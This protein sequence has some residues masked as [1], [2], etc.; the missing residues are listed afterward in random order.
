MALG[1]NLGDTPAGAD[2][3][4]AVF[5]LSSGTARPVPYAALRRQAGA[6][7][8]RLR[9]RGLPRGA[10][11][12]LLGANS[13]AFLAA[14]FGILRAGLV[15]VPVNWRL[16]A[17]TVAFILADAGAGLVLADAERR[18]LCPP[19][20]PCAALE[21][22]ADIA[23]AAADGAEPALSS[24]P[25]GARDAALIL[26]TSGSTGRAKGV[27][28]SHAA[29]TWVFDVRTRGVDLA[30]HRFVVAAPLY[31]MNALNTV[32]L[33]L[34]GGASVVLLPQFKARDY[35]R[36]VAEYR[37]T[38]LTMVPTMI[39]LMARESDLLAALDL[40]CTE[41]VRL[42]SAPLS[43]AI[44]A[45]ARRI[46]PKATVGNAYGTTEIGS[47]VFGPHPDGRPV[48][49]LAL[50]YP[51]PAVALRLRDAYG[52]DT[53]EGV[54][55]V[56]TPAAMLGYHGLPEQTARSFTADGYY[57]TNDVMRRDADGCFWFVGR[58]DDMFVCGG[59]N[60]FPGEVE[61]LLERH[62]AVAEAC[63]VP[64][65]DAV[66]GQKPFAFVVPRAGAAVDPAEIKRY[67]LA[68][69]PA[70]AHPRGVHVLESMPLLGT[71]KIDR[72][73]LGR[74]AAQLAVSASDNRN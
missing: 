56:R 41:T 62:P 66:K 44:V 45:A 61:T 74:Q 58:S 32:Q 15:A 6:V 35:L 38:L 69:G 55:E 67:A 17:A 4:V 37:G 8:R 21:D 34:R 53:D 40:T 22:I 47:V 42:G 46:F 52:T 48:P 7:A 3:A 12:G 51:H 5:D 68:E 65:A 9:E 24:A 25:V 59:E 43:E 39:G 19:A 49:P 36:A 18:P 27:V 72:A 50:G 63:V 30:R 23:D 1:D 73:A 16:P 70:H 10:R 11:V 64:I 2:D 71:G 26:Y 57:I 13:V 60:V 28:L 33:A 20:V 29:Y 14:Y 31:H 54:L